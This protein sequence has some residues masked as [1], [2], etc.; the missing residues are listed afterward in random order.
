MT[1]EGL[2]KIDEE[3][4]CHL[5]EG[6]LGKGAPKRGSELE[7]LAD[8]KIRYAFKGRQP[9]SITQAR[10]LKDFKG[11]MDF[12]LLWDDLCT[13]R[14]LCLDIEVDGEQHFDKPFRMSDTKDQKRVDQ[15]KDKLSLEQNR[16]LV[17]LHFK[18]T[19][20]W[21]ANV[22]FGIKLAERNP[23]S[24]FI[25]YSLSYNKENIVRL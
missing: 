17:R 21:E 1:S 16:K 13:G 15:E 18:D 23:N 2:N 11:G 22:L 5:C 6:H 7:I 25:A 9:T 12:T 19:R 8:K 4:G 14:K 10:V 3:R 24:S 20:R